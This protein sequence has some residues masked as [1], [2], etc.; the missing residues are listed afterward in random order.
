MLT[1]AKTCALVGLGG[2]IVEVEVDISAGLPAFKKAGT[3]AP[4]SSTHGFGAHASPS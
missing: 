3:Q 2:Q 1:K 4:A